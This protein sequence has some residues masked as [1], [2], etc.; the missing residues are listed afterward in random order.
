MAAKDIEQHRFKPGQSGNPAGRPKKTITR[1]E[2]VIGQTFSV[3]LSKSD[4]M[5]IIE[6]MLEMSLKQLEVIAKDKETPVFMVMI[7]NAIVG[8]IQRKN[9]ATANDI[10]NRIYGKPG[11]RIDEEA[12]QEEKP[13]SI[14]ASFRPKKAASA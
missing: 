10:L 13:K 5:Q 3:Q 14:L 11:T 2:E 1:L 9:M 8:D 7:A 12:S 4:K 6:S